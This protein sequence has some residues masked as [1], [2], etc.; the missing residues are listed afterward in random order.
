M[1]KKTEEMTEKYQDNNKMDHAIYWHA[2]LLSG[3]FDAVEMDDFLAW[4]QA[5][6][7]NETYLHYVEENWSLIEDNK[8]PIQQSLE[9]PAFKLKNHIRWAGAMVAM[10]V[11]VGAVIT[12]LN[13]FAEKHITAIGEQKVIYLA[14]G[15]SVSLNTDSELEV[16]LKDE[17]RAVSL[18]KGEAYFRVTP[19]KARPFTVDVGQRMIRVVGTEFNIFRDGKRFT[20]SVTEG[21]V[22]ILGGEE[23]QVVERQLLA[24]QQVS[25]DMEG[26]FQEND[27]IDLNRVTAWRDGQ[28]V[29]DNVPLK[30]FIQ[31]LN[32]YYVGKIILQDKELENMRIS[33]VFQIGDRDKAIK[34]VENLL[35]LKAM[36][37]T[38]NNVVLYSEK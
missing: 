22:A 15:S 13:P 37:L 5:D 2:R 6:E 38:S 8:A 28:L 27:H 4:Q 29:Y 3:D 18:I 14:D 32:R 10:F 16:D 11:V 12:L 34:A 35:P 21:V 25:M 1:W 17:E 36:P 31:D 24:G 33:G 9:K 23:N 30:D 20:L 26:N 19:D 7:K